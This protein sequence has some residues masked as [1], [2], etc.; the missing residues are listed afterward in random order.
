MKIAFVIPPSPGH[1]KIIRLIDCSHEAK[2]DYLWQPGDFMIISSLLA[3]DDCAVLIDGTADRLEAGEFKQRL[4]AACPD[5]MFFAL[6]SV[7]WESDYHYFEAARRLCGEVPCY[8]MG[9]I[10]HEQEY[11]SFILK[12]CDGVVVNPFL[13]Q[14]KQMAGGSRGKDLPGVLTSPDKKREV[15]KRAVF[16]RGSFPCHELFQ[17][18][19]YA[20]PFARHFRFATVT[21]MWGCPFS[22]TYCP[23]SSFPPF[24]RDWQDVMR[25]LEHISSIGIKELFFADKTFCYPRTNIIPLLREMARRFSFSWS[26]YL[27]PAMYE[28]GMLELMKS[29][30]CHTVI[31]GIDSA[32][33]NA[34]KRYN[35]TVERE[36]VERLVH[37]AER[38]GISVCADFIFGLEHE[39]ENAMLNTIQYALELPLD[40]ASF[41]I[42]APFPGTE[43]RR[44]AVS[45]GRIAFGQGGYDS[46]GHSGDPGISLISH[47][48]ILALRNQ[49]ARRFY[50]RP[51][52]LLKRLGRTASL[53][54]LLIQFRQMLSMFRKAGRLAA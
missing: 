35:R 4:G 7:C 39:D 18:K 22:C 51:A 32:D 46:L 24:V 6:S 42:A 33:F 36:M 2:A 50:L 41:N 8:V 12:Q 25:E 5:M 40:Y 48:K 44:K 13:L 14:L 29:A 21:T 11:V 31:T 54:H 10:F 38:V 9:D 37:H 20:F 3:P 52:Y 19:G 53:E 43:L 26:C 27:H 28:E 34:L 30:G 49:A 17:K 45:S 23:D 16:L 47:E 15:S 1:R